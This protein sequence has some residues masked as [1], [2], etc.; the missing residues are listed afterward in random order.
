[1]HPSEIRAELERALRRS[2]P[3]EIWSHLDATGRVNDVVYE[4]A[5]LPELLDYVQELRLMADSWDA[6]TPAHPKQK[7]PPRGHERRWALSQLVAA[8]MS[9]DEQVEKYRAR[10]LPDGLLVWDDIET[11]LLSQQ[12]LEGPPTTDLTIT[13]AQNQLVFQPGSIGRLDPPLEF[14]DRGWGVKRHLLDFAL[15]GDEWVRRMVVT[16]DGLLDQLRRL[17][18]RLAN[19]CGWQPV[20]CTVFVLAGI[21]PLIAAVRTTV[22]LAH[23]RFHW[24]NRIKLD[25][26]PA[27]SVE[28]V[29]QA[30]QEVRREQGLDERR[31]VTVKLARLAAF[32][33][34]KHADKPWKERQRLW[35][36]KY[37]NWRYDHGSNFRRDAATAA[38]R[39]LGE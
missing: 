5:D 38:K 2:L 35:N 21:T 11:W 9:K 12:E 22:V 34:A 16:A 10:C 39:L 23:G 3:E 15:P 32:A 30:L 31:T 1:M 13:I 19:T 29:M 27:A 36:E 20:Q 28:E 7:G 17:S 4:A 26:D 37:G 14:I 24:A 25:I 6:S 8:E 33:F 18:E